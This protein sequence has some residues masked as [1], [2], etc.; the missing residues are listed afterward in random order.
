MQHC[1]CREDHCLIKQKASQWNVWLWKAG[2]EKRQTALIRF[3]WNIAQKRSWIDVNSSD[4]SKDLDNRSQQILKGGFFY[5]HSHSFFMQRGGK[6]SRCR[7]ECNKSENCGQSGLSRANAL[8][9]NLTEFEIL[10]VYEQKTSKIKA[11][12]INTKGSYSWPRAFKRYLTHKQSCF[13]FC[14]FH[15]IIKN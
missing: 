14:L 2:E 8:T 7:C 15:V 9:G 13:F 5:N 3:C 1:Q 4:Y 12:N 6:K 10:N 11:I